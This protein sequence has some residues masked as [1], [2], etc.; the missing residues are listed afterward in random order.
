M[1]TVPAKP[2]TGDEPSRIDS[3][4]RIAIAGHPR[5][6][7]RRIVLWVVLFTMLGVC[8]VVMPDQNAVMATALLAALMVA[9]LLA[10]SDQL[11]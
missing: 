7:V 6:A 2:R 10:L 4:V 9:S 8:I 3:A 11:V 5:A 1:G